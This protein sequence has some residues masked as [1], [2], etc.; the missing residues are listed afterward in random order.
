MSHASD[1]SEHDHVNETSQLINFGILVLVLVGTVVVVALARP[2]IFDYIVPAVL[3]LDQ[4]VA[5]DDSVG[6]DLSD[7]LGSQDELPEPAG[8]PEPIETATTSAPETAVPTEPPPDTEPLRSHIVQPGEN[9][10]R[11]ALQYG[12]TVEAIIE[13]NDLDNPNRIIAGSV[14]TIPDR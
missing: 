12:V 6:T 2:L 1:S 13:A 11:I 9:L 8:V 3:G 4:P 5:V 10:N 7:D 14:L